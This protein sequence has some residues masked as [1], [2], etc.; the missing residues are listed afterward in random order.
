MREYTV[1][2]IK[3]IVY[4]DVTEL[5]QG[6]NYLQNWRDAKVGDWVKADD[7]SI[8]QIIRSGIMRKRRGKVKEVRYLG[9]CTGTFST[10]KS[11]KFH[12][13]PFDNIYSFSG[14][15]YQQGSLK[16][17][18]EPTTNEVLFAQYVSKGLSPQEAY[19]KVYKTKNRKHAYI[20]AGIL[21]KTERIKK[22][23]R[24]DLKPVLKALGI[25]MELVLSGIR[26][27]ATNAEKDSD[28][29]KA[30]IELESYLEI[31]ETTKV[32]EVTGALFQG[33]QPA[34]LEAAVK[35]KQLKGD[36]DG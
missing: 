5:P 1:A 12:T 29:L 11:T 13:N 28:R 26:D 36:K 20:S 4:D 32:Q 33:F 22:L 14:K 25:D 24:E 18:T 9:T 21:V 23:M 35:P 17:R 34:Q 3:H 6:F 2:K 7:G 27:I 10:A 15:K 16:D 19:L 31:K 30:L 8:I